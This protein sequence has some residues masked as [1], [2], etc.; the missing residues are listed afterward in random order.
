MINISKILSIQGLK[1]GILLASIAVFFMF[2]GIS[3][4][5]AQYYDYNYYGYNDYG[6]SYNNNYNDYGYSYDYNYNYNNDYYGYTD[7][8][9]YSYPSYSYDY[10]YTDYYYPSTSYS[11]SYPAVYSYPYYSSSYNY[12]TYS[13][14]PAPSYPSNPTYHSDNKGPLYV[15]CAPSQSHV[16]KGSSVTWNAYA[17]GGTGHYSYSW[18]GTDIVNSGSNRVI[19]AYYTPGQKVASVTVN[20]GSDSMTAFC[21]SVNVDS[22]HY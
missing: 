19:P 21:G 18:I 9:S 6:Y 3:T 8:Y 4:A 7:Y 5:K 15:S 20:S 12:P 14:Y 17:T 1:K 2:M 16:N 22:Y 10:G 11:Y 13:S